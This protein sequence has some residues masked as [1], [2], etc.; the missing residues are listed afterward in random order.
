[1]LPQ[2]GKKYTQII[3]YIGLMYRVDIYTGVGISMRQYGLTLIV[4]FGLTLY[5]N[6]T[7]TCISV[8]N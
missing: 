8:T 4:N 1:M 7:G 3:L 2:K 5:N 6:A